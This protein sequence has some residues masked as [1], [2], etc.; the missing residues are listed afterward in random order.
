MKKM[1]FT[2]ATAAAVCMLMYPGPTAAQPKKYTIYLSNN[3]VGNDW[4]QQMLRSAEIAVEKEPLAD[5]VVLKIEN[6]ETTVQAQ[7]NSL[8][9]IIR[10]RPDA[11]VVDASSPTALNPTLEKACQAGILV[12]AFDQTVTAECAYKFETDWRIT[13]AVEAEWMAKQLDYKGNLL[14]DRGLPGAAISN[15][16][17]EGW[18]KVIEK[19]PD[20]KV[21]G[22]FNG[23]FSLGPEQAGVANLLAANPKVDGV[24]SIGYGVGAIKALKDAGREVV[25]VAGSPYN[26]TLLEC[27]ENEAA[28]CIVAPNPPYISA[29]ALKLAVSILD[30]DKPADRQIYLTWPFPT[31]DTT[32]LP[33]FPDIKLEKIAVG[34]NAFPDL[35]PGMF[36]PVSPDWTVIT[37]EEATGR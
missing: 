33:M 21:V 20:M 25:P 34:K 11:I 12:I 9:N 17:N 36:L 1:L 5:R 4:R 7:I 22:Y 28:K 37:P 31:T 26:V 13:A 27:A 3:F 10:T 6:A 19:Y 29:E 18:L 14:V 2:V 16:V 35:P 8:N 30:G 15:L 32:P 24:L 23:E